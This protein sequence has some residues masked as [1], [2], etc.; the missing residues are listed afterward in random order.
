[1]EVNKL[2]FSDRVL[3]DAARFPKQEGAI[4]RVD[5]H[6]V[7]TQ[8]GFLVDRVHMGCIL[9]VGYDSCTTLVDSLGFRL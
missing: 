1:M 2:E 9:A 6:P 8:L 7:V 5:Y 3:S 4:Q